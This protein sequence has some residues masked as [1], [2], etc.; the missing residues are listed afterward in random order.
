MSNSVIGNNNIPYYNQKIVVKIKAAQEILA[1]HGD[2]NLEAAFS[3][4]CDNRFYIIFSSIQ[5]LFRRKYFCAINLQASSVGCRLRT[6]H[7]RC[8]D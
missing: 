5:E 8:A 4:T 2:R 3:K 6:S 7:H 1:L